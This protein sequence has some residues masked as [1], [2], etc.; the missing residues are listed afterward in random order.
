MMWWKQEQWTKQSKQKLFMFASVRLFFSVHL[1]SREK[2]NK[3]SEM[4]HFYAITFTSPISIWNAVVQWCRTCLHN[5]LAPTSSLARS[6]S[7]HSNPWNDKKIILHIMPAY[8]TRI[9]RYQIQIKSHPTKN[10]PHHNR[11][12]RVK[13]SHSL[14]TKRA[15]YIIQMLFIQSW[16]FSAFSLHLVFFFSLHH[17]HY[18]YLFMNFMMSD[19]VLC[20]GMPQH[21]RCLD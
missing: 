5:S 9:S 19:L 18:L 10:D 15:E 4:V 14:S 3:T 21:A 1:M 16:I 12:T 13:I 20:D 2:E 11:E 17:F 7:I 8:N 6:H